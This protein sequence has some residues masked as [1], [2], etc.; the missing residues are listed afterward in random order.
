MLFKNQDLPIFHKGQF[1]P[2]NRNFLKETIV[3]IR[4]LLDIQKKY[5]K[6][7]NDTFFNEFRDSMVAIY[8]GYEL[9]NTQKHGF[10]GKKSADENVFLEVKQVSL[11]SSTWGAT[12]NDTNKE[13][14][15]AFM[16]EKMWLAVGVWHGISELQFIVYGQNPL[17]GEYLLER[18]RAVQNS[19][20]RST[21]SISIAKLIREYKFKIKPILPKNDVITLFI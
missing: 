13:K 17:I 7:D 19:S 15:E 10:D 21:Q 6:L 20:T 18:V 3:S 14:A 4:S 11:T 5:K 16:D 9:I 2:V 12:F 8:L 1:E